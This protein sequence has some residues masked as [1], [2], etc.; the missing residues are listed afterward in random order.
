M[1]ETVKTVSN[2]AKCGHSKNTITQPSHK[3]GIFTNVTSK[4]EESTK[5]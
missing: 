3:H 1:Q 5:F 2:V 4:A